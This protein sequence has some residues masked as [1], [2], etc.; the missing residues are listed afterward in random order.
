[1]PHDEV[2][3]FE[4]PEAALCETLIAAQTPAL[5]ALDQAFAQPRAA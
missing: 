4:P 1:M 2:R 5:L 3:Y